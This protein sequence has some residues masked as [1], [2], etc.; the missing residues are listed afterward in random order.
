MRVVS[1]LA[2]AAFGL[3]RCGCL[4]AD[5]KVRLQRNGLRSS[6]L[7]PGTCSDWTCGLQLTLLRSPSASHLRTLPLFICYSV[8]MMSTVLMTLFAPRS[9]SESRPFASSH[10]PM[11]ML[12]ST[13]LALAAS[14][15]TVLAVPMPQDID[16][17]PSCATLCMSSVP[18]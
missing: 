2:M 7:E 17:A 14:A 10:D 9:L 3:V 4:V 18:S 1:C 15:L 8:A 12:A 6:C 13:F 5:Q 16:S 11:N